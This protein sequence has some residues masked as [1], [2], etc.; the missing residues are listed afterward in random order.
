LPGAVDTPVLGSIFGSR[1]RQLNKSELVILLKTTIIK[2]DVEWQQ[3]AQEVNERM[4]NLR[5][6]DLTPQT[7]TAQGK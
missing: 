6:P 1:H 3:Q 4:Q 2:G 5:R 7:S